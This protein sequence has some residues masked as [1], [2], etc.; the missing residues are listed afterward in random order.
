MQIEKDMKKIFATMLAASMMLFGAQ[1]FAQTAVNAGYLNSTFPSKYYSHFKNRDDMNG[2]Y[3]GASRNIPMVAGVGVEPGVNLEM[4]FGSK[5]NTTEAYLQVPV[6]FNYGIELMPD[7]RLFAFAG[8]TLSLGLISSVKSK[9]GTSQNIYKHD[10]SY[11][12]FDV[13]LGGGIGFDINRIRIKVG[14]NAGIL[15][16]DLSRDITLRRS[17]ITLG[18]AFLF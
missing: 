8:P 17:E 1:A 6:M 3:A 12:R 10:E 9:N 5:Y 16:R 13:M 4:L 15:D 11:S 2:F 14:Y 7:C 18:A